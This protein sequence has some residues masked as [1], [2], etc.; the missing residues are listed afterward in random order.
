MSF[1]N[2]WQE[3]DL[4]FDDLNEFCNEAGFKGHEADLYKEYVSVG[5]LTLLTKE[6]LVKM[7]KA[8][9][10]ENGNVHFNYERAVVAYNIRARLS[11]EQMDELYGIVDKRT[12]TR[13]LNEKA[14]I[15]TDMAEKFET[16]FNFDPRVLNN[17]YR[18]P[19]KREAAERA[20]PKVR[21]MK[22]AGGKVVEV[23]IHGNGGKMVSG[24]KKAARKVEREEDDDDFSTPP[25]RKKKSPFDDNSCPFNK[26]QLERVSTLA[27]QHEEICDMID[28]AAHEYY[29][30]VVHSIGARVMMELWPLTFTITAEGDDQEP[31]F[32]LACEVF[33]ARVN[34]DTIT[35]AETRSSGGRCELT[36]DTHDYAESADKI[37]DFFNTMSGA[38]FDDILSGCGFRPGDQLLA[39][40][41]GVATDS[42]APNCV[43]SFF[44][45]EHVYAAVTRDKT[46]MTNSQFLRTFGTRLRGLHYSKLDSTAKDQFDLLTFEIMD[47]EFSAMLASTDEAF[48]A[49]YVASGSSAQSF[50]D[51]LNPDLRKALF[52]SG[53]RVSDDNG[54]FTLD[55]NNQYFREDDDEDAD[56]HRILLKFYI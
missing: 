22:G 50:R 38:R 36:A 27:I 29:H 55:L 34:I 54:V 43:D 24:P 6:M 33:T 28:G 12:V 49:V 17:V 3:L 15:S 37:L 44:D 9:D 21:L 47:Y 53:V 19:A 30:D 14:T 13:W 31:T 11:D 4:H 51:G 1:Q 7:E 46:P 40:N 56:D 32:V 35:V 26:S 23:A 39:D 48:P 25:L 41:K 42:N 16:Y 20:A 5:N 10:G 45:L 8:F 18:A 2:L 52:Q